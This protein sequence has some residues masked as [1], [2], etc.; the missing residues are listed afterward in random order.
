MDVNEIVEELSAALLLQDSPEGYYTT[1]ELGEI[2]GLSISAVRRRLKVL[3]KAG[4]L[5]VVKKSVASMDG[6]IRPVQAYR[7]VQRS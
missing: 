2:M 7:I 1:E 3:N 4:R 6:V 5:Q